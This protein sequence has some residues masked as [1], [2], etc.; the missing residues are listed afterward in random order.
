MVRDKEYITVKKAAEQ[1]CLSVRQV[2]RFLADGRIPGVEM[3]GHS[4]LIPI[5]AQRP[6]DRRGKN[7]YI[8]NCQ[9][10]KT[11]VILPYNFLCSSIYLPYERD[12]AGLVVLPDCLVTKQK[13][14]NTQLKLQMQA[15]FA[16]FSGHTLEARDLLQKTNEKIETK[17]CQ[18]TLSMYLA[19]T[20]G[21]YKT[22]RQLSKEF[23]NLKECCGK[24]DFRKLVELSLATIDMG[25]LAPQLAPEWL[26]KG[27]VQ[28]LVAGE[29]TFALYQQAK[30]LQSIGAYEQM[31]ILCRTIL[32]LTGQKGCFTITEI[33][34]KILCALACTRQGSL[35]NGEEWLLS[36]LEPAIN[37]GFIMPFAENLYSLGMFMQHILEQYYPEQVETITKLG[38]KI[39]KNWVGFHNYYTEEKV[40]LLL[41][42]RELEIAILAVE[43]ISYREIAK[44]RYVS[45][46]RVKNILQNIYNKLGISSRDE[47]RQYVV[48]N[49]T[50]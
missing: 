8:K 21:D 32:S 28:D 18:G 6:P 4:Y 17:L 10:R 20:L 35:W 23:V 36:A 9:Q 12:K 13:D 49:T 40:T 24:A 11:P 43:H 45:T 16:A 38:E 3:L 46:G 44:R 30:Y 2:Q 26:R 34:M 39:W 33:Y 22:Y 14:I 42:R 50:E 25:M 27:D 48:W 41:T 1:W 29:K 47:L 31:F 7:N 37:Y 5:A 15:E 19:V